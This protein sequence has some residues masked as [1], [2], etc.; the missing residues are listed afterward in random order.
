MLDLAEFPLVIPPLLHKYLVL[1]WLNA[2]VGGKFAYFFSAIPHIFMIGGVR[3]VSSP[4]NN[5]IRCWIKVDP[6]VKTII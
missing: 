6:I 2:Q 1:F 5:I 3:P 4:F